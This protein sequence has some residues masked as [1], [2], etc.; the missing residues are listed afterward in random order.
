MDTDH[1]VFTV[2]THEGSY[3]LTAS[4][5]F[6]GKDILIAVWGGDTPHIGAVATSQ[7]QESIVNP[8]KNNATVS[9]FCFPGHMEDRLIKPIAEKVA[10]FSESNVVV[11]GGTHWNNIDNVGIQKVLKN[12]HVL[13][14]LIMKILLEN[15]KQLMKVEP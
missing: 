2:T 11:T 3:D 7:S 10:L 15:R 12:G 9:I 14:D 5:R 6:I 8:K 4:I 1:S 13:A